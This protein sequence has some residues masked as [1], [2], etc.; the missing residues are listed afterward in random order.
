[1]R[2]EAEGG[3]G[4]GGV[5]REGG[6]EVSCRSVSVVGETRGAVVGSV[7]ILSLI[8]MMVSIVYVVLL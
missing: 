5:G 2:G 1:M 4:E 7:L 6:R 8:V 3:G